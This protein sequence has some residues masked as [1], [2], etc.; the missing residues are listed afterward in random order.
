LIKDEKV[1]F[2]T[3]IKNIRC[4]TGKITITAGPKNNDETEDHTWSFKI[5]YSG[6]EPLVLISRYRSHYLSLEV[7]RIVPGNLSEVRELKNITIELETAAPAVLALG[8]NNS[9]PAVDTSHPIELRLAI[10]KP[11]SIKEFDSIKK[12]HVPLSIKY[13]L[14]NDKGLYTVSKKNLINPD[15]I[16][17]PVFRFTTDNSE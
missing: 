7:D 13:E 17:T 4:E 8:Q 12:I 16:S 14:S 11:T 6:I 15:E 5:T 1:S 10:A 3:K 9:A 2:L